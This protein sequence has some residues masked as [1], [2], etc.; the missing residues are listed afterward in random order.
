[1]AGISRADGE[2]SDLAG[3]AVGASSE[4]A[5]D[6]QRQANPGA[7]RQEREVCEVAAETVRALGKRGQVDIVLERD[8]RPQ[9]LAHRLYE[10][11][12]SPARKVGGH[13]DVA[14]DRIED[15]RATE[16]GMG[17]LRPVHAG[18]PCQSMRN[19]PDLSDQ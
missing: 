12:P 8:V 17:Y 10:T 4:L 16:R 13:S 15:A 14:V 9:L 11:V 7:N 19:R 5:I 2:I 3:R 1:M 6:H 18:L